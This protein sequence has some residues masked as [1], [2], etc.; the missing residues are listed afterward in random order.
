MNVRTPSLEPAPPVAARAEGAWIEAVDGRSY[1][2]CTSGRATCNLGHGH[3]RVLAAA[4][5]QLERLV[6]AGGVVRH[7]AG[8][9]LAARL[10]GVAP[11]GIGDFVFATTGGEAVE[12]ALRLARVATGR[13][14]VVAF[15]GGFHGL[16]RGARAAGTARSALGAGLLGDAV[17]V[18]RFPRPFEWRVDAAEAADRALAGLDELHRH[19]VPPEETACYLVE[20]VQGAGGCHPAGG[21]FLAGLR[22][23]ADRHGALLVLDEVQTGFGRTGDWFAALRYDVRPDIV[24]MGKALG[25]GFPLSAIGAAP[26]LIGRL[27]PNAAGSTFGGSPLA[28]AAAVAGLR[29]L[30]DEDLIARARE[31]G[32]RAT[33]RLREVADAV[34]AL[35][36]VR[37]LGLM[38]GLEVA[39]PESRAPRP[40][41]AAE[42]CA[43][44]LE[45]GVILVRSGPERNVIRLL[46]PLVITDAELELA[47]DAIESA[48]R[49]ATGAARA[50]LRLAV[51]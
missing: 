38:L 34:P 36:D 31:L 47:L 27:P 14:A 21:R 22:D 24:A 16:T 13:P 42:T 29:A 9:E 43:R 39:D 41:L 2:D 48:L 30:E 20:P 17:R 7:E 10:A 12:L 25:A 33:A 46:P 18:A 19:E 44:A 5:A 1:L 40:D 3:P 6:H 26:G 45:A 15:R 11:E 8:D 23:R 32:A 37:G 50:R 51:A 49:S 35:G 4:R 28:C